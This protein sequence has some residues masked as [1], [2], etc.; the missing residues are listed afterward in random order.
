VAALENHSKGSVA[1]ET[2]FVELIFSNLLHIKWRQLTTYTYT[3]AN[4]LTAIFVT[5][6]ASFIGLITATILSL[7][8][9]RITEGQAQLFLFS[10]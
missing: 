4:H 6:Y 1:N 7:N 3:S 5:L 2:R 9:H 8:H 10:L